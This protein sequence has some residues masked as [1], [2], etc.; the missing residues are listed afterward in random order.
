MS[1]ENN[2]ERRLERLYASIREAS[3]IVGLSPVT[4][5]RLIASE[6]LVAVKAGSKTL[7]EVASLRS[8]MASLPRFVGRT[9]ICRKAI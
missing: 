6:K 8:Y 7:V 4:L 1:Y 3:Q 9:G 2:S 5:Y